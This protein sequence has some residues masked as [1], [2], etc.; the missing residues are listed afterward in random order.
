[1]LHAKGCMLHAGSRLERLAVL[2]MFLCAQ[3]AAPFICCRA[4]TTTLKTKW[5][6]PAGQPATVMSATNA[7]AGIYVRVGGDNACPQFPDFTLSLGLDLPFYDLDND[8]PSPRTDQMLGTYQKCMRTPG[9]SGLPQVPTLT[10][11][12]PV[13]LMQVSAVLCSSPISGHTGLYDSQ[14]R[15]AYTSPNHLP[16]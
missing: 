10:Q 4:F 8:I 12:R 6:A 9:V 16:T 7:C 11:H 3:R 1:M 14:L 2:C 13:L 15:S 5:W